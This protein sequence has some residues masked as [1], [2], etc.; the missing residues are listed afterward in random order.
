MSVILY[1]FLL[2]AGALVVLGF[3]RQRRRASILPPGPPGDPLIGHLLR[4]PSTDS[5]LVF[6]EW[7][8]NIWCPVMHLKVLG[9]SMII[10]DSYEAAVD[11]LDKRG[12]IYSD[13]PKFTL[14]E[15]LGWHP[16]LTFLQYGKKFN[17]HRQM[18]Q[19]YLSRHKIEGFKR[20]QTQEARML[21][22]NLVEST[23]DTYEKCVSRF[24]TGVIT[25]IVVGHQITSDD[26]PYLHMS[27]MV[28]EAMAKTGPP[29][30]SPLDFFPLSHVGVVRTWNPTVRELH[31]FPLRT[32]KHQ[33]ARTLSFHREAEEA[34]PSFILEQLEDMEEGADEE[35]LKGAAA[36]MFGA[37][38]VTTW[39]T[40]S[41][42][43]LAM[44]LHPE[45]QTKAQ[46]QIDSVVGG[47]R[48]P[49]FGDR[50]DLPFVD[51]ILQETLR[52]VPH[53]VME[54]DVYQG[55]L[56]PKGS[57]VFSNVRGMSLDE[58]MY[59]NPTSF[60]PQRYLPT[61]V[62][63]SEPNFSNM[64]F[65]FG[66]RICTGEFVADNSLWIA[67][68]S[69]LAT[70]KITNAVDENG[71]IIVP[72]STSTDGLISHPKD[73]RCIISPRSPSAKALIMET[74]N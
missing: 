14:Y 19:S 69:I 58:N 8:K 72:E 50:E 68:A 20:M 4:M 9:R 74:V 22:K 52:C 6:H 36:T 37:R 42:F 13:R 31:E 18:H 70:C 73:V 28:F 59:S 35:D 30:S 23:P 51:G 67:I 7:S 21:V 64:S 17:I 49:E 57:L 55:M 56:I 34:M 65:G 27:R 12:V 29:G 43:I 63:R 33:R 24:A 26:D 71:K 54:D 46:K 5:A 40:L 1:C 61:P 25:Q 53:R 11:L 2:F 45:C 41:T 62:G 15:L 32:V 38:E 16:T 10:L 3:W 44:V 66:R 48:L 39:G 47:A 60:N